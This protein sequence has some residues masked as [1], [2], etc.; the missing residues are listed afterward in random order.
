MN[1]KNSVKV[2]S[3]KSKYF[4]SLIFKD[5]VSSTQT[6][7]K[8][9]LMNYNDEFLVVAL[10]QT[11]GV[12]RFKRNWESP[13]DKGFYGS[14]VFRPDVSREKLIEFNLFIALAITKTIESFIDYNIKIKWPNDIYIDGKKV[15]GF[16][17]EMV[18]EKDHL[19]II[20]GIGINLFN[21]KTE[22]D[23][24]ESI[25]RFA[26]KTFNVED[27]INLLIHNIETYYELFLSQDFKSIRNEYIN[28]SVVL[29]N[30]I[31]ITTSEEQFYAKAIDIDDNGILVVINDDG[32]IKRVISADIE[33]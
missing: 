25:E 2:V 26:N 14:F 7:A 29:G 30:R 16:L 28:Y 15:C 6:I 21:D 31:K 20:C 4:K 32:H 1:I 11:D 3:A 23:K 22:V 18:K 13:K 27:F 9:E 10:T 24:K 17:T 12:G 8:E 19:S 33:E 5:I